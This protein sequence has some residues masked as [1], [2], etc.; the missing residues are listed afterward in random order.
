M[1][2]EKNNKLK[3]KINNL[4]LTLYFKVKKSEKVIHFIKFPFMFEINIS[5]VTVNIMCQNKDFN[6][7]GTDIYDK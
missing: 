6:K 3:N 4:H 1:T 2:A 5:N 7:N